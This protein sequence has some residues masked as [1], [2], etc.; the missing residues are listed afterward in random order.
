MGKETRRSGL[1]R[2]LQQIPVEYDR[3]KS[4]ERRAVIIDS[5]YIINLMKEIPLFNGL[6]NRQY[7]KLLNICRQQ[8]FPGNH[9]IFNLGDESSE[10]FIL[11]WGQLKAVIHDNKVLTHI[12]PVGLT[13]EISVFTGIPRQ[14]S[15]I[16]MTESRVIV[17]SNSELSWLF[18]NDLE[19]SNIVYLNTINELTKKLSDHPDIIQMLAEKESPVIL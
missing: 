18:K 10:L 11:I 16:T 12:S 4:K 5:D 2:R 3:R 17:I 6:D 15:L 1:D 9:T 19:L 7:K 13:G 8:N 14:T